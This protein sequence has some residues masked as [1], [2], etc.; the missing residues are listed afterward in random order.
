MIARC[1]IVFFDYPNAHIAPIL[2]NLSRLMYGELMIV[3][4]GIDLPLTIP[5]HMYF[6]IFH[7][8][9]QFNR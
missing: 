7:G 1:V 6:K 5:E 2:V 4:D 9:E 3:K 8:S